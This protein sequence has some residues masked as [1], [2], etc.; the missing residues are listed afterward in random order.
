MQLNGLSER[1]LNKIGVAKQYLACASWKATV[2]YNDLEGRTERQKGGWQGQETQLWKQRIWMGKQKTGKENVRGSVLV[3]RTLRG[4]EGI[5]EK[6]RG[7]NGDEK[8]K[9]GQQ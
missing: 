7:E 9:K 3:H 6:K 8:H 5:E 4:D 2:R 1:K